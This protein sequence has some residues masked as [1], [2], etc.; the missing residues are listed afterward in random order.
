MTKFYF[1][2]TVLEIIVF[3]IPQ[4]SIRK[5]MTKIR[6]LN[7]V[8]SSRI[9][10]KGTCFLFRP[11]PLWKI[12]ER[13]LLWCVI[14]RSLLRFSGRRSSLVKK[15]K[16]IRKKTLFSLLSGKFNN[17]PTVHWTYNGQKYKILFFYLCVRT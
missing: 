11:Y 15:M 13:Y 6:F 10:G 14:F 7:P 3:V 1:L 2:F 5:N 17:T 16:K 9:K 8:Q 12:N 4:I